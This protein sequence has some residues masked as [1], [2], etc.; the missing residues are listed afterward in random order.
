[1]QLA[2]FA[3]KFIRDEEGVTA[4]EYGLIAAL[5]AVAIIATVKV[6]GTTLA[7][8]FTTIAAAL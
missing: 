1:M 8:L 5:I 6:V 4:I 2:H 7:A 3:Q